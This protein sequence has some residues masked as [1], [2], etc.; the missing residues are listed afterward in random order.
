MIGDS[1]ATVEIFVVYLFI[2]LLR[3]P[4]WVCS[5]VF[6]SVT[7]FFSVEYCCTW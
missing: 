7:W 2:Y 5:T 1:C 4:G 3:S 6:C